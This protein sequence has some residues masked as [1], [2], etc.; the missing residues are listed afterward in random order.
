MTGYEQLKP[1]QKEKIEKYKDK[2]YTYIYSFP[3]EYVLMQDKILLAHVRLYEDGR[4]WE[5]NWRTGEYYS[6]KQP[7]RLDNT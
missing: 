2:G 3:G 5:Q 7:P 1:H 4:V 6:V